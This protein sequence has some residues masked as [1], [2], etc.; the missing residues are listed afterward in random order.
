MVE[1]QTFQFALISANS[2]NISKILH[3]KNIN[4]ICYK[5]CMNNNK[6]KEN[7]KSFIKRKYTLPMQINNNK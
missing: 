3:L 5:T 2:N 6:K 4:L 1:W 7:S